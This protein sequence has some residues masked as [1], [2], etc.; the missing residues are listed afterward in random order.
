MKTIGVIGCG[1]VGGAVANGFAQRGLK[2]RTFDKFKPEHDDLDAMMLT[3]EAVFICVPTPTL[4][5]GDQDISALEEVF[6]VLR[7]RS[8]AGYIVVKSTVLPGTTARLAK[9]FKF[10]KVAH[11]PE[12]L[13]AAR[14]L[15]DFNDQPAVLI[16]SADADTATAI[17][18]MYAD[19][20]F[21]N[22][23]CL[24][25]PT[26]TELAKYMHNLHLSI[27]VSF[28][29][30]MYEACESLGVKYNSVRYATI[31]M[32]GIGHGHTAV[33]GPDGKR[34]FGGMCFPKDTSAFAKW[35]NQ[36]AICALTLSGAILTNKAVRV[37]ES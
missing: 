14:P 2:V 1:V 34:G 11:N 9:Q 6:A 33:P 35:A 37:E 27:K 26:E 22:V 16:G 23:M 13:T 17:G 25:S 3:A 15:E 5:N 4:A 20:G 12:F 8:Y 19:L 31:M 36:N 30:E 29:N 7:G 28:C 10:T 32:G 21:G 18:G 24:E